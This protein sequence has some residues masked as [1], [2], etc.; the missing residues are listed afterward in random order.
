MSYNPYV[1]AFSTLTDARARQFYVCT[2]LEH[3]FLTL[4]VASIAVYKTY[5]AGREC[6][7]MTEVYVFPFLV[8]IVQFILHFGDQ[9]SPVAT[10]QRILPGFEPLGLL[11]WGTSEDRVLITPCRDSQTSRAVTKKPGSTPNPYT[12]YGFKELQAHCKARGLSAKG[13]RDVLVS[14]LIHA[15]LFPAPS[16]GRFPLER[17]L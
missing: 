9:R 10:G 17:H 14:R 2:A 7:A 1:S 3:T 16:P 4:A 15:D 5:Q 11:P 6:R 12:Q 13:S 8:G